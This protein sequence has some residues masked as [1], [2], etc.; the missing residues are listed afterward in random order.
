MALIDEVFRFVQERR[1]IRKGDHV[2][3]AL[4]GGIDSTVLFHVLKELSGPI[5][6]TIG[7]A[8]VNHLLRGEESDRDQL[9]VESLAEAYGAPCYVKRVD[10]AAHARTRGLSLQ[11]AARELRYDFFDEI[12]S[13]YGY[14]RI[15]L[16]HTLD[17]RVET[18]LLR[19]AKGTGLK[20]FMSIP[21][22]RERIIRPL[23]ATERAKIVRFQEERGITYVED[24]SNRKVHYER[25]F[26]RHEVVPRLETLNPRF[27]EKVILLLADLARIN[28]D[29]ELRAQRFM[30]EKVTQDEEG[31]S[32]AVEHLKALDTE[33]RFRVLAGIAS[34]GGTM[35]QPLR[36]HMES[37]DHLL[38]STR[39]NL[40][41]TLPGGLRAL[42]AYGTITFTWKER[43]A[44]RAEE[45]T[46][47]EGDN[48]LGDL[49]LRIRVEH[50]TERPDYSRDSGQ[51]AFFDAK[52]TGLL[53]VRRFRNGDRFQPLG[54]GEKYKLKD[55]F[56]SQRV[57]RERRRLL[58]LVLSDGEIIWVAG[59]R[60]DERF[61]VRDDTRT[62]LRITVDPL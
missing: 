27:R 23:L 56:I 12:A 26:I 52:R 7:V 24:S 22:K 11:H 16:A 53:T 59:L 51:T 5:G 3:A 62:F 2:L 13:A 48:L 55:F 39:P 60:I 42:K 14:G 50:L 36:S 49:N 31:L 19:L 30:G 34:A 21:L 9:F 10:A 17:D 6:F 43:E 45:Y 37:I 33:T 47:S 44:Q 54:M 35:F 1:L 57:P 4:S 25:N 40:G 61:K 58:P 15:A 46:L 32:V 18:A 8:H 28:D 20:G 38:S 29:A 41:V